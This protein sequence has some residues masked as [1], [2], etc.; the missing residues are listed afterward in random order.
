MTI[1]SRFPVISR[2]WRVFPVS[3]VIISSEIP[4]SQ[5]QKH[6]KLIYKC[7]I[8]KALS[9]MSAVRMRFFTGIFPWKR[10]FANVRGRSLIT[11]G[12]SLLP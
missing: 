11:P 12:Q 3:G 1:H 9:T 7:L 4:G 6:Q 8:M 5:Y 2:F 10:V